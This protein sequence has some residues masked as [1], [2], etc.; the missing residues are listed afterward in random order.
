MSTGAEFLA[1]IVLQVR[2]HTAQLLRATRQ[3]WL[4]WSPPGTGNQILWHAGHALWVQDEL[5]V[6][7]MTGSSELPEGWADIFGRGC[8]PLCETEDW[9]SAAETGSQLVAQRERLIEVLR[10]VPSSELK[11]AQPRPRQGW[12]LI[13]GFIHGLHDEARHNG[14]I[15][16]FFKLCR[17]R[18]GEK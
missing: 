5:W 10:Q 1:E 3:A 7:R 15:Y 17:H 12:D 16:L 14:E 11:V 4:T 8:R 18:H 6:R 13:P 2:D 9:P